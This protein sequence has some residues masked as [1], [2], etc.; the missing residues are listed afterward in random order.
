MN[1]EVALAYWSSQTPVRLFFL[2]AVTGYTYLSKRAA[3][4]FTAGPGDTLKNSLVFT[5]GFME[6]AMW[7]WVCLMILQNEVDAGN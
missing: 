2:F 4:V 1:E 7:F 6:V 3:T 5:W